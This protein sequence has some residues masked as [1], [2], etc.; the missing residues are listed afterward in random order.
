M[1]APFK[2]L[3]LSHKLL[4]IIM[5]TSSGALILACAV[6]VLYDLLLYRQDM[7]EGLTVQADIIGANSA[8]ALIQE[9]PASAR[10]TLQALRFQPSIDQAIIYAKDGTNFATY[11]SDSDPFSE[12][13]FLPPDTYEIAFLKLSLVR[14]IM[15]NG[16][17]VGSILIQADL[18]HV[19][20]R[21]IAFGS[22]SG[23]ILFASSLFAFLLSNRLQALI[24]DPILRLTSLAQR[25]SKEKN[26]SLREDSTR[27]DEIGTLI[28][29]MNDMLEQIQIRDR[30]LN[31][32]QEELEQLVAH[33]TAELEGLHRQVEL[34]LETAGEGIIGL[35]THGHAI[36]AN[37]AASRMLGWSM[38]ELRGQ[39]F[40]KLLHNPQA[41]GSLCLGEECP[42]HQVTLPHNTTASEGQDVFWRKDGT[43]FP[44]EYLSAPMRDADNLVT[45]VVMTIRD[46][47]EQKR[48]EA[49]LYDSMQ[50]AEY[51]NHAKSSFLANMSHEIR[52]PMNGI[53][54]MAELLLQTSQTVK[55]HQFTE[56][57][58]RSAQHLL[59]IINDILDFSKIEA[60][61]L[62]MERI[63]FSLRH[64]IEDTVQ[65]F[66]EPTQRKGLEL[67]CHIEP[68]VPHEVQG[69]PGRLRQ[70][71]TNLIGNALKF[72][73]QGEVYI[74]TS[75]HHAS[76]DTLEIQFEVEDTGIGIPPEAH[77]RIFESF[78]QVDGSTTRKFGGTGLG[79]TIT[80]ELVELMGGHIS[81]LSQEGR[82]STFI[83]TIPFHKSTSPHSVEQESGLFQHLHILLIEDNH[84][85]QLA[86]EGTSSIWG[87]HTQTANDDTQ[88][89]EI[90]N[91]HTTALHPFDAIFID[92]T[93]PD[94]D[95]IT[96][97]EGLK[98]HPAIANLPLILL[99][100]WHMTPEQDQ[101]AIQAGLHRQLLKPIRQ[102]ALHEQLQN[103]R[104][105]QNLF[106][107]SP[108]TPTSP[109]TRNNLASASILLA[110]DHQ[111]NQEIVKAMADHL[112]FQIEIVNNGLEAVNAL[113]HQAFDLVLMDWQMPELD[114]L[115]ATLE[116]R[117]QGI[118]G[119]N[120]LHL[121]IIAITAH[122]SSQDRQTCLDAGTDDVLSKPF[123]LEQLQKMLDK[124][125]PFFSNPTEN[126]EIPSASS[127]DPTPLAPGLEESPEILDTSALDRIRILQ[128]P[129]TPDLVGKV[130][131]Q[132]FTHTPKLLADLQKGLGQA[133]TALL[134]QSAHMLKSSSA[135][136][137]ALRLSEKCKI[138]EQHLRSTQSSIG[139]E[140]L[141]EAVS[142]EYEIV[143]PLLA[144]HCPK[145]SS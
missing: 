93:L 55:Q 110:E 125:L 117:E 101:R 97:A 126:M 104:E 145:V 22:I 30:Q 100:P 134:L 67:I 9:D 45:G 70:I 82:G 131:T 49:V 54:G 79:L 108:L 124:W 62:D 40:H 71:L 25:V 136:V 17:R 28:D 138:L 31:S 109:P 102:G 72:T 111:V 12:Y 89:R 92:H 24:S 63:D 5:V 8:R 36:F 18:D 130:L 73:T 121:P 46:V 69:D 51:A 52:T 19:Q 68:N 88:A 2:N 85:A 107:D 29:G 83:F 44:V 80:K 118:V 66:A 75:L 34:I 127:L 132:F 144:T 41:D 21:W 103:L 77:A 137:G 43:S 33:R 53:L 115:A 3:S 64:T 106:G 60:K 6:M 119:L 14:E 94:V 4:T 139:V 128:R 96:L 10:L 47:T 141:V 95:G 113:R 81:L 142:A 42:I 32:H 120:Q 58:H 57:L 123:T 65:L 59:R 39:Y 143:E 98:S 86:F 140:S 129:D 135:N 23:G 38:E 26:Y 112:G 122:A 16:E 1:I 20:E 99:T 15:F 56:S 133:D 116:I 84:R 105:H 61:K 37:A 7:T 87:V 90:L 114:G 48:F 11:F 76:G 74:H 91:R 35:D 50:K 78:S 13:T 27:H